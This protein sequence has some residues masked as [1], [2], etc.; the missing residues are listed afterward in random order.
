MKKL[1]KRQFDQALRKGH[2]RALM[3]VREYGIGDYREIL[4]KHCQIDYQYWGFFSGNRPK[5][6]ARIVD[7]SGE[8]QYFWRQIEEQIPKCS[9]ES[10][11]NQM[12]FLAHWFINA[13][14]IHLKPLLYENYE[15]AYVEFKDCSTIGD[16]LVLA[17]KL[18]G[19]EFIFRIISKYQPEDTTHEY[20]LFSEACYRFGM[21]EVIESLKNASESSPWL[22]EF[23]KEASANFAGSKEKTSIGK[24][25]APPANLIDTLNYINGTSK[26]KTGS[27]WKFRKIATD[28]ELQ[29]IYRKM[30]TFTNK[31]HLWR[32][33]LIFADRP[34][35]RLDKFIFDLA[36]SKKERKGMR[37]RAFNALSNSTSSKIR[38]FAKRI[39]KEDPNSVAYGAIALFKKNYRKGDNKLIFS[40]LKRFPEPEK[41]DWTVSSLVELFRETKD[42]E[43][44]DCAIWAYENAPCGACRH[45]LV[46][47]LE[48]WNLLPCEILEEGKYDC[49]EMI[50]VFCKK[51]SRKR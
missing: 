38:S 33:L 50:R 12:A 46:E 40:C 27:P 31:E 48:E 51:I 13:G 1:T 44:F 10:N 8:L 9:D 39:I 25:Y 19:L 28:Q 4:A 47:I 11:L 7:A 17:D 42:K 6:L 49:N 45:S 15:R 34:L 21:N 35:P 24:K 20:Y 37:V 5:W 22:T 30:K 14:A 3:H 29:V 16:A 2:G 18:M 36:E 23:I 41:I 32:A 43:L 26:L